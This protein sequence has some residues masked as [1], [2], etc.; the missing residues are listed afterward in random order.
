MRPLGREIVLYWGYAAGALKFAPIDPPASLLVEARVG[1]TVESYVEGRAW[2]SR[3]LSAD[4][5]L[6]DL[7]TPRPGN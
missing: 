6:L 2:Q 3:R 1:L 7:V 5:A 4:P